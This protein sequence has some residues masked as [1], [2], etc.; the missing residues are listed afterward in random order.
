MSRWIEWIRSFALKTNKSYGCA[1]SDPECSASYR[2]KFG[3][4]KKVPQRVEKERMGAE[5]RDA[6][7]PPPPPPPP[8]EP[9]P[10]AQKRGRKYAT[11]AEAYKAKLESNK[12]KRQQHRLQG[13][14][15]T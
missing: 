15:Y 6:P 3:V 4:A 11:P 13:K 7:P 14:K 10:V 9:E 5:D 1:L 8:I 12:L 2:R